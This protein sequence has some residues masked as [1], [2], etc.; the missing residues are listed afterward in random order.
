MTKLS[1]KTNQIMRDYDFN[2]RAC[3]TKFASG[4]SVL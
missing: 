4:F 1:I 2:H 3:L